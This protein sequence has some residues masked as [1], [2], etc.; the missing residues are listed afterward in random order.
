MDGEI[1]TDEVKELLEDGADVRVVDIRD[2]RSF[3]HSHIPDSEN[4]PF[5][6]L[7]NRVDELEDA[8]HIVTV[9]PHG[10]ASVQAAQLIGS[11]QGTADARVQSMAGGLEK[12]G[13]K[14]GLV[15]EDDGKADE[16]PERESP[17]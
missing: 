1:T 11:Y 2:E 3:E 8:D 7:T 12:Y 16:E 9:C 6:E 5:H 13:M 17:F 14:F 15:R 10:K 4:I